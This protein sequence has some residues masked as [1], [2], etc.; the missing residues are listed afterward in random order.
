MEKL[1]GIPHGEA[2][3]IGMV[4]AAKL[5]VEK[6]FLSPNDARRLERIVHSYG[7]PVRAP[8]DVSSMLAAMRKD[9]KREGDRIH[10]IFL[11]AMGRARVEEIKLEE[12]SRLAKAAR[13]R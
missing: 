3:G 12:L 2:V 13:I 7:L 1:T 5:S 8:V 10:F 4:L 9:K 11:E 6:G